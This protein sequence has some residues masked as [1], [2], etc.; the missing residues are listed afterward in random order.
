[1]TI[2][3]TGDKPLTERQR[4]AIDEV[5]DVWAKM[6]PR[7]QT[8]AVL[9]GRAYKDNPSLYGNPYRALQ[10]AAEKY[11]HWVLGGKL[12]GA[13]PKESEMSVENLT[14]GELQKLLGCLQST[15]GPSSAPHPMLGKYVIVRCK[16]AGVHAGVLLSASDRTAHLSESRRLW[17]WKP[18][19]GA[20][21]LSGVATAGLHKDSKVGAPIEI[22]QIGRAH[23]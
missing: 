6:S 13:Q 2:T 19:N 18:A 17:Y 12:T 16:D 8:T 5:C 4:K 20:A 1:M 23:V 10:W 14:I 15:S 7:Q 11:P 9:I 21:F 22:V 3:E